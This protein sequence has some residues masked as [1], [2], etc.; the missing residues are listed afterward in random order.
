MNMMNVAVDH[1]EGP[2]DGEDSIEVSNNIWS[3]RPQG[4]RNWVQNLE[5]LFGCGLADVLIC[6]KGR[7]VQPL[8]CLA[9]RGERRAAMP[10]HVE[11]MVG[12]MG[13]STYNCEYILICICMILAKGFNSCERVFARQFLNVL[14]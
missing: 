2:T 5:P 1:V 3:S 9:H 4:G 7:D 14:R 12:K 8:Q 13:N 11:E 10:N 6:R